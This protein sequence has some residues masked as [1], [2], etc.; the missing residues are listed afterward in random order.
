[1]AVEDVFVPPA[2]RITD[3]VNENKEEDTEH[4]W[5]RKSKEAKSQREYEVAMAELDRVRQTGKPT[6]PESPFKVQGS[7]NL[8]DLNVQEQMKEQQKE[9]KNVQQESRQREDVLRQENE[10]LKD[11]LVQREINELRSDFTR[12]TSELNKMLQSHAPKTDIVSQYE[13]LIGTIDRLQN[14]GLVGSAG[15]VLPPQMALEMKKMDMQLQLELAQ[16]AD[17]RDT[18]D[19]EWQLT[20]KKWEDERQ[21][22]SQ[23]INDKMQ[24]EKERNQLL[25]N[26]PQLIGKAMVK[27]FGEGG[28]GV[29]G[30]DIS[31][32]QGQEIGATIEAG[33]G[34]SG[35]IVCTRCQ[36]TIPIA[37][38]A[39]KTICPGCGLVYPVNRVIKETSE[40]A[41]QPE[42]SA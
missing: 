40:P 9:A 25:S 39:Q 36:A 10:K 24:A 17:T 7:I 1:M 8:G 4:F 23:E 33:M 3:V 5:E 20:V 2:K 13:Q 31:S 18:R 42:E 21:L 14:K 38:D 15:G 26:I 12:Q 37:R 22:R 29:S 19:K 35:E 41:I 30:G 32:R 16:M 34:E 27:G 6:A 28:A 11:T